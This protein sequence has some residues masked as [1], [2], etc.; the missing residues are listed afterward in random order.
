MIMLFLAYAE[1]SFGALVKTTGYSSSGQLQLYT[2]FEY[3]SAGLETKYSTFLP[4]GWMISYDTSEYNSAGMKF[5]SSHYDNSV[6]LQ[7][8]YTTYEYNS[9]GLESKISF[10]N[11]SGQLDS[12]Q[13]HEYNS[14]GLAS[15]NS[16][17]NASG[18]LTFYGTFEYNLAGLMSK[19][20]LYDATGQLLNYST[21]EY[22]NQFIVATPTLSPAPGTYSTAQSVTLSSSTPSVTIRYTTNNSEPNENS[23]V[24]TS[25]I[26]V[27]TTTTIKAKA[28]KDGWTSNVTGTGTYTIVVETP[29]TIPGA[30]TNIFATAG[31][32]RAT[33]SFTAPVNNGGSVITN[34]TVT[35]T[36]GGKTATGT[37]SPIIVSGLT[38]GTAYTFSV[39]AT[40][41]A[42][43]STASTAS[44][45]V[46]PL[47]TLMPG[48]IM[49]L[50]KNK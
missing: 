21:Y 7:T 18:Q 29:A 13:I 26:N 33:V 41:A 47:T 16:F 50:L 44:N 31:N 24:Y 12:Y 43:N 20:L 11:A 23:T 19:Y 28:Y 6:Q 25:P 46:T 3:N 22:D 49:L 32:G 39:V 38:S 37:S 40:N 8:T 2:T 45:S 27:S 4:S 17:F 1:S 48:V 15:K 34:Y 36:P 10:F 30:P 14:A 9:A 42:G 35:S 5:K